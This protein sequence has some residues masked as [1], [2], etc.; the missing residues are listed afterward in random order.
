[1]SD[2]PKFSDPNISEADGDVRDGKPIVQVWLRNP[3]SL[4][5]FVTEDEIKNLMNV[6]P[7]TKWTDPTIFDADSCDAGQGNR[8]VL[9]LGGREDGPTIE[10][11]ATDQQLLTDQITF[12]RAKQANGGF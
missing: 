10:F 11:N 12:V 1:M 4:H 5:F 7:G 2:R 9:I 3:E 8:A 6:T